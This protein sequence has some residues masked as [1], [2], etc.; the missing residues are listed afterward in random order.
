MYKYLTIESIIAIKEY[1]SYEF[2]ILKIA[3]AV[4]YSKSTVHRVCRLLNQNLLP[5]EILNQIQKKKQNAG[6]KLI[7]LTL[8]EINTINYLLINKNYALDI[9]AN[10]L[11]ENK[12]KSISTKTLYNMFKTNRMGFDENNLLRKGKNKPH[13]R[14]ETRGRIN[15]CKSIHE[16][17]L[18]IPNI[19]NIQE[20]GHLEG[21]TI[22]GK[23]HKSSII[24]LADIWSKTTIPL[25]SK[26]HKAEN[27][28]KSIIKFISKLQKGTVKTITF[29]RGKEFS[30]WKLIEK[31]CNVKIYF[32]D[33]GKPCQRGLNENNNGI[34][35]RY[36]PKSTDLSL[37]KQKDLNAIAF[38]INSTPRK[39]LSYKS[40]I[41]LIQ[42]F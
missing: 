8:T 13:K 26:N 16:R 33:P 35:R 39:S 27:I 32:A 9:I 30:K 17:N 11:K 12:I 1:K 21:D 29:D 2:S 24:T 22:I 7:I 6:R 10:F 19:K 28:T 41:D 37:Y 38:Q 15:N 20:F 25:V 34:L 3:K 14:K 40:P 36:L 5:L 42:L 31:I 4:D 18:I 23:D